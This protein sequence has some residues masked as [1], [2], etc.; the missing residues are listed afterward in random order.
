MS[1]PYKC[2]KLKYICVFEKKLWVFGRHFGRAWKYILRRVWLCGKYEN[3]CVYTSTHVLL[4][5][6]RVEKYMC[7]GA[8]GYVR[9]GKIYECMRRGIF[10]FEVH[11]WKIIFW[12]NELHLQIWFFHIIVWNKVLKKYINSFQ[13]E[14]VLKKKISYDGRD[15]ILFHS[16]WKCMI[17]GNWMELMLYTFRMRVCLLWAWQNY[18]INTFWNE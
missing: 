5:S 18:D 3:M 7:S 15:I 1:K 6:A 13:V 4:Q 14:F 10:S 2:I 11:A 16:A 17:N 12:E 8:Y 9:C